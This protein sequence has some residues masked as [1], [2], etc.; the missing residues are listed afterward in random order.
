MCN[1]F[2]WTHRLREINKTKKQR[3]NFQLKYQEN[4]PER[5]IDERDMFNLIDIKFK[6][7]EMKILKELRQAINRNWIPRWLS[8]KAF[9]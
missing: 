7:E 3:N 2:L 6:K 8:G 9:A 4:S 1:Y 5:T